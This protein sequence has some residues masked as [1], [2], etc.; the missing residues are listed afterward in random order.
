[1]FITS[2]KRFWKVEND[3][4]DIEFWYK[5]YKRDNLKIIIVPIKGLGGEGGDINSKIV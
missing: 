3:N 5:K 4:S 2:L 1:M